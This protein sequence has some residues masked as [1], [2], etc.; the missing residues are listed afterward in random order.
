M[1]HD[2]RLTFIHKISL[3]YV[4]NCLCVMTFPVILQTTVLLIYFDFFS[5]FMVHDSR[6]T[7]ILK[8]PMTAYASPTGK[9]K[10]ELAHHI[11]YCEIFGHHI[12][13]ICAFTA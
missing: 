2:S 11:E 8:I 3:K 5:L 6:L 7:F 9:F 4:P 10:E 13:F 1:V 12:M